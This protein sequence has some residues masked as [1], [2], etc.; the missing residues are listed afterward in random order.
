VLMPSVLL[1]H[2]AVQTDF[3]I[4]PIKYHP[5]E[6]SSAFHRYQAIKY[7]STADS[8]VRGPQRISASN[9][10]ICNS[11]GPR[12]LFGEVLRSVS[13]N[14]NGAP[15]CGDGHDEALIGYELAI[16]RCFAQV[17]P[18]ALVLHIDTKTLEQARAERYQRGMT[19]GR[20]LI[21]MRAAKTIEPFVEIASI[22][23]GSAGRYRMWRVRFIW[24]AP[25][26]G[27]WIGNILTALADR[28]PSAWVPAW[29][30]HL[31]LFIAFWDGI[32]K[33]APSYLMLRAALCDR[34]SDR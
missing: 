32:R 17:L 5:H 34:S 22:L 16:R 29:T 25:V 18:V 13:S 3:A 1:Q 30:C 12:T 26:C 8:V 15:I 23:T 4:G 20:L 33:V 24:L 9:L 10:Y 21:E 28:G 31:P 7:S 2:A 6:T 11:S 14:T 19:V 27:R